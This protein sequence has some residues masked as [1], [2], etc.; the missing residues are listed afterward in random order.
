M[1]AE[2]LI[3]N[4][5]MMK[6][7]WYESNFSMD[8]PK[9]VLICS[10]KYYCELRNNYNDKIYYEQSDYKF[11]I[12]FLRICGLKVPVIV[13]NEMK[14][15]VEYILMLKKDYERLEKEKLYERFDV[16]FNS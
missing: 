13:T 14:K 5:Y 9:I 2:D 16:M 6:E 4:V 7:K 3:D 8:T 15:D 11:R 10:P 12:E 1:K